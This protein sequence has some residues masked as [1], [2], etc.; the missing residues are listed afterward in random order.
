MRLPSAFG[1]LALGAVLPHLL[2][3]QEP[4]G[5][6]PELADSALVGFPGPYRLSPL[7]ALETPRAVGAPLRPLLGPPPPQPWDKKGSITL[8]TGETLFVDFVGWMFDEWGGWAWKNIS[9]TSPTTWRR[10]VF[11]GPGWDDNLFQ[12]NWLSHPVQ[13]S[14]FY[15]AGRSNDFKYAHSLLLALMGSAIWECCGESHKESINDL[16]TTTLGGAAIGESFWRLGTLVRHDGGWFRRIGWVMPPHRYLAKWILPRPEP[17]RGMTH[18]YWELPASIGVAVNGGVVMHR[19]TMPDPEDAHTGGFVGVDITYNDFAGMKKGDKPFEHFEAVLEYAFNEK[20][21]IPRAQIRGALWPLWVHRWSPT[22]SLHLVPFQ[23]LDY[24]NK[25][26][27]EFGAQTVGADLAFTIGDG[28]PLRLA[29][30]GDG[31]GLFASMESPYAKLGPITDAQE[32]NR[33]YDFGW[34]IGFGGG[35]IVDWNPLSW[36]RL[37]GSGAYHRNHVYV[38]HGSNYDDQDADHFARF[39]GGTLGIYPTIFGFDQIGLMGEL[40]S[41][42]QTSEFANSRFVPQMKKDTEIR[43]FLSWDPV[44]HPRGLIVY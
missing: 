34:G 41:Y 13:G 44:D 24:F 32:R 6:R 17:P 12:I 9:R 22:M 40:K 27:Y 36:L 42:R 8:A 21:N 31:G 26:A 29:L 16:A 15:A 5:A 2:C 28:T 43:I 38:L 20:E 1:A 7:F 4:T 14:M 30:M 35:G 23:G 3:G 10:N 33:E 25:R 39:M 18:P 11:A 19:G 37:R